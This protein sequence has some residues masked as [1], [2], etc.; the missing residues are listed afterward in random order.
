MLP[1]WGILGGT[2][3]RNCDLHFSKVLEQSNILCA[4]LFW[5][6]EIRLSQR[7]EAPAALDSLL[8]KLRVEEAALQRDGGR[9]KVSDVD[10]N[11]L[12]QRR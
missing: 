11:E 10:R 9:V 12:R 4:M 3:I 7:G 2:I 1:E 8:G 5:G 6:E